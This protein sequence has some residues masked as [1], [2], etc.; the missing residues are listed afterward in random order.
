MRGHAGLCYGHWRLRVNSSAWNFKSPGH[1][2]PLNAVFLRIWSNEESI[3]VDEKGAVLLL[4]VSEGMRVGD[5]SPG[6][7]WSRVQQAFH[8]YRV[9]NLSIFAAK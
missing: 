8:G 2:G 7:R 4:M 3:A 1:G 5:R 9:I 6:R